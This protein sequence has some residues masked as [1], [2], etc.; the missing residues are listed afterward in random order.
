MRQEQG[1]LGQ[2]TR[3]RQT[4]L[5]DNRIPD[6]RGCEA[7]A[8]GRQNT[9]TEED[10]H[11]KKKTGGDEGELCSAGNR[12]ERGKRKR[13]GRWGDGWDDKMRGTG[14]QTALA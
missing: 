14:E 6:A 3:Q 7:G 9:P 2:Q 10:D 13:G 12:W 11:W 4:A 5:Q 8:A 1:Q